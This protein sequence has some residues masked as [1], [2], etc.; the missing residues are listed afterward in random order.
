MV[1][2]ENNQ[3]HY[4]IAPLHLLT[5]F[6]IP[7]RNLEISERDKPLS[8]GSSKVQASQSE[9]EEDEGSFMK[10]PFLSDINWRQGYI[11]SSTGYFPMVVYETAMQYGISISK[12]CQHQTRHA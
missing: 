9:E 3:G 2:R 11:V 4:Q 7:P 12:S 1:L 10:G 6:V 5:L 8:T